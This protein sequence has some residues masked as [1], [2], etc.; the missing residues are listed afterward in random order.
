MTSYQQ[1][2]QH[3]SNKIEDISSWLLYW[4]AYVLDS[5]VQSFKNWISSSKFTPKIVKD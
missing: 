5:V 3:L 1:K 4:R 2:Y